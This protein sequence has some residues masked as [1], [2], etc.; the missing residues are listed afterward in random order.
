MKGQSPNHWTARESPD[1]PFLK[2]ILA[3]RHKARGWS[4][5]SSTNKD[6]L[7]KEDSGRN[8]ITF[9]KQRWQDL[10][11]GGKKHLKNTY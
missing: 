10:G 8:R 2:V 11:C 1:L 4:L 6:G 5:S 9:G 3:P 7:N